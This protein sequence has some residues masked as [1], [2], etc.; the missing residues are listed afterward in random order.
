M[1]SEFFNNENNPVLMTMLTIKTYLQLISLKKKTIRPKY[2][3]QIMSCRL[4]F[5]KKN[6]F[7]LK[8]NNNNN[9]NNN[10]ERILLITY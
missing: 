10:K 1:N 9:N 7:Q 5:M 3:L 2:Y 4:L 8:N 6:S